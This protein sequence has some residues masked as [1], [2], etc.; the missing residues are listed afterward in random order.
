MA[1][2][3]KI[4]NISGASAYIG[5]LAKEDDL[6][7]EKDISEEYYIHS[8]HPLEVRDPKV[9]PSGSITLPLKSKDGLDELLYAFFGIVSSADNGDGT[10]THTFTVKDE[11]IPEFDIIKNVKSI[12]EKYTGC[13]VRSIEIS[14]NASGEFEVSVEIIAKKGEKA[15]GESEGG[16]TLSKTMKVT[17]SSITWG[18]LEYGIGAITLTLERDLAEDGFYLNSDVGRS[19]IP[20]GNFKA[21][22]KV[23]V[24][25]DDVTFIQDFLSGT[26]KGL[27][28]TFQNADGESLIFYLPNGVITSR[29]KS[30]DVD[31]QLLVEEVE[32]LGLDDGVNGSAYAELTN[33]ISSYPRT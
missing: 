22:V 33:N 8:V 1:Q 23:D 12:Q 27:V 13:K 19:V 29:A 6:T 32:I 5:L 7:I 16:Y 3:I 10:Y 2:W 15:T 31:K 17:S 25:I 26:A 14:A 20:E 28:I 30:T 11:D 24:L 4:G 9:A 21:S 18:G